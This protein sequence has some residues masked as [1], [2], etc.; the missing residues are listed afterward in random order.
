MLMFFSTL[1]LITVELLRA[2]FL[3]TYC[4]SQPLPSSSTFPS[5]SNSPQ[6]PTSQKK[7]KLNKDHSSALL[8]SGEPTKQLVNYGKYF[9]VQRGGSFETHS[10][11]KTSGNEKVQR[12]GG[13]E[14]HF[15]VG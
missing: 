2:P 13:S 9:I 5:S 12:K 8:Y 7:S 10:Q 4:P 6:S 1:S 14:S 11:S 15:H 3:D